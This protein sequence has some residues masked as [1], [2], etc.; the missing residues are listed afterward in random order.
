[1]YPNGTSHIMGIWSN[2]FYM[3]P[4]LPIETNSTV[5]CL[6]CVTEILITIPVFCND[7]MTILLKNVTDDIYVLVCV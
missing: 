1:M 5:L 4:Q 6:V 2:L 7:Y 3:H